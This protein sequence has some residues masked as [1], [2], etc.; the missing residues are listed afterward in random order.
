[1]ALQTSLLLGEARPGM[2]LSSLRNPEGRWLKIAPSSDRV[3]A[4]QQGITGLGT[5]VAV[6]DTGVVLAHPTIAE[7][8][9]EA[10]GVTGGGPEDECGHGTLVCLHLLADSPDSR[11][12]SVKALDASGRGSRDALI[13]ALDVVRERSPDLVNI[14][15][16]LYDPECRGDCVLCEAAA[17]C[18]SHGSIL[19]VAAGNESGLTSCP[20]KGALCRRFGLVVGALDPSTMKPQ[21]YS[22]TGNVYEVD[23]GYAFV[24]VDPEITGT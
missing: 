18:A 3:T 4:W 2:Y 1:V 24:P 22:G 5:T 15:A 10:L 19:L 23:A 16:G 6:V 17:R 7:Q 21:R 9:D 20:G 14:S 13:E 8:L 11:I 12:I